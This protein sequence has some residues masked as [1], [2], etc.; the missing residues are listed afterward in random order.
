M[1]PLCT[2]TTLSFICLY[3]NSY[4]RTRASETRIH[5]PKVERYFLVL[6]DTTFVY[7]EDNVEQTVQFIESSI[8]LFF[9]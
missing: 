7:S 9:Y 2:L 6:F 3:N 1:A 8:V 5:S 4:H